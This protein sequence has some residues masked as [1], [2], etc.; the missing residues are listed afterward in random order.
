MKYEFEPNTEY[1]NYTN[2]CICQCED[3]QTYTH[4]Q[5]YAYKKLSHFTRILN[6]VICIRTIIIRESA[7]GLPVQIT[8][9]NALNFSFYWNY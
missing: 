5:R 8:Q 2:I 9:I 4:W 3:A 6:F 7:S 1:I